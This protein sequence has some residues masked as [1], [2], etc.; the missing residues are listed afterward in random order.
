MQSGEEIVAV[1]DIELMNRRLLYGDVEIEI[2]RRFFGERTASE[3]EVREAMKNAAFINLFGERA[4]S[5]ARS[6]DLVDESGCIRIEGVPH[7][8]IFRI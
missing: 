8:Q 5:V 4:L 3:E 1:C 6:L 7:A 2:S